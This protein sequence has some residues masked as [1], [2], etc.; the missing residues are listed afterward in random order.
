MQLKQDTFFDTIAAP[1][2][3]EDNSPYRQM[4]NRLNYIG[5][6]PYS[7]R[8]A[9]RHVDEKFVNEA[10]RQTIDE[11]REYA[12]SLQEKSDAI[13][14]RIV[15]DV[16]RI[17]N[18]YKNEE[19]AIRDLKITMFK[20]NRFVRNQLLFIA[21]PKYSL[22]DV[23]YLHAKAKR[24]SLLRSKDGNDKYVQMFYR[25]HMKHT[26][27]VCRQL[28]RRKAGQFLLHMVDVI[29]QNFSL[30]F[31]KATMLEETGK[32][33]RK[34]AL[35]EDLGPLV[36]LMAE[37]VHDVWMKTRMEQGWTY[38][39]ERNDLLKTHPCLV[40]YD[41]LPE[42]EKVYDRKTSAESLLFI[43]NHGYNIVKEEA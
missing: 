1:V 25:V 10:R 23:N 4:M 8:W 35:P 42:S 15:D 3:Y 32:S 11:F 43:M 7:D 20:L 14:H 19:D 9:D 17:V 39:E 24:E 5:L 36:E 22:R 2:I 37:R 29:S 12:D 28:T 6:F 33:L 13:E 31:P 41:E 30:G 27:W 26:V 18:N 38:G 16:Y 21:V 34:D 40:P